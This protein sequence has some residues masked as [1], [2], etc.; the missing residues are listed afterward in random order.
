M[1]PRRKSEDRQEKGPT[2]EEVEALGRELDE[3]L[4][5]PSGEEAWGSR[6]VVDEK[7]AIADFK[8]IY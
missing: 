2:K 5:K 3:L 8:K 1:A 7:K 6:Q 4:S